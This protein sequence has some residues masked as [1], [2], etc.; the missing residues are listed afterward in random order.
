MFFFSWLDEERSI[1]LA[2]CLP[3]EPE[4]SRF[5]H[6][7]LDVVFSL[8]QLVEWKHGEHAERK[9]GGMETRGTR[10]TEERGYGNMYVRNNRANTLRV[11]PGWT[12]A[13]TEPP[14]CK[15]QVGF[16]KKWTLQEK[17][18]HNLYTDVHIYRV[19]SLYY[20]IPEMRTL[21]YFPQK[22]SCIHFNP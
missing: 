21:T 18:S 7:Q 3:R 19:E 1:G 14:S 10:R 5:V 4:I 2:T 8:P 15:R 9:N 13:E 20:D 22:S 12:K 17:L 16:T 11:V 6:P